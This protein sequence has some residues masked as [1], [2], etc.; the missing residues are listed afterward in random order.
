MMLVY[1]SCLLIRAFQVFCSIE[2]MKLF[3]K[4]IRMEVKL[5]PLGILSSLVEGQLYITIGPCQVIAFL[6]QLLQACKLL[7]LC[8][9]LSLIMTLH[10]SH[11]RMQWG[12]LYCG[13]G[14]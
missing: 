3:K 4:K 14:S 11:K 8:H 2:K 1:K 5:V 6:L 13:H 10:C 12:M 9:S 7:L